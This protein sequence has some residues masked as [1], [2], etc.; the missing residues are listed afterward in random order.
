MNRITHDRRDIIC[1]GKRTTKG[2][3]FVILFR[4]ETAGDA[5]RQVGRW[6]VSPDYSLTMKDA[7]AFAKAINTEVEDKKW[8][9]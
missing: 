1:T 2:E 4:D 7:V 9:S 5:M 6:A 8:L 3:T